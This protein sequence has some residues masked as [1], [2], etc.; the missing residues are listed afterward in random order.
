[1]ADAGRILIMPKGTYDSVI[2]YEKLDL[3]KHNDSVWLAKKDSIGIEPT[4]ANGEYWFQMVSGAD[5]S[6]LGGKS[7]EE[8]QA[9][10]DAILNGD[11]IVGNAYKLNGYQPEDFVKSKT[12]VFASGET[13]LDWIN[14]SNGEATKFAVASTYP[15]DAPVQSEGFVTVL[16]DN[17]KNRKMAMF[18]QYN[19]A[20]IWYR[21]SWDGAWSTDWIS[22]TDFVPIT[23]GTMGGAL[24]ANASAVAN[25]GTK[26]IRNIYAG[27]AELTAGSSALPTGDIY[28]QIKS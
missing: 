18:F 22:A 6:S 13:I 25:L 11:A 3:V 5:A 20:K 12:E 28:F 8:W 26:Q 10:F 9:E 16:K 23:G 4:E 7:A 21:S 24:V 19:G 17:S 27:T 15:S 2:P 14:N 1:M